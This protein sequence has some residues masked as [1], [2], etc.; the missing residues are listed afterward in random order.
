MDQSCFKRLVY[1]YI[2]LTN[3]NFCMSVCVVFLHNQII[4]QIDFL[5]CLST[6]IKTS[7]VSVEASVTP[8]QWTLI[9]FKKLD[10]ILEWAS[11]C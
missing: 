10:I 2:Y 1:S 11:A 3:T 5:V 9:F 4:K 8:K 7:N 6:N